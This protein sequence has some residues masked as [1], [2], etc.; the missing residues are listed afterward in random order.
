MRGEKERPNQLNNKQNWTPLT[1]KRET[2]TQ[3][4]DDVNRVNRDY[5]D[6]A[7]RNLAPTQTQLKCEC[8]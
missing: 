8:I 5:G 1:S 2:R 3:Y 6:F 7:C 4:G